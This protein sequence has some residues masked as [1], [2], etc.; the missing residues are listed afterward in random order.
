MS[1]LDQ[2]NSFTG[3]LNL[4]HEQ[5]T[6]SLSN[7]AENLQSQ[8]DDEFNKTIEQMELAGGA[9][10]TAGIGL[11]GIHKSFKGFK[12]WKDARAEKLSKA[13]EDF[14]RSGRAT[15]GG[16]KIDP[17]LRITE[18][19]AKEI[20]GGGK[21]E[22][23]EELKARVAENNRVGAVETNQKF[24]NEPEAQAQGASA[25]GAEAESTSVE[26]LKALRE[27]NPA[28]APAP[29]ALPTTGAEAESDAVSQFFGGIE[30]GGDV[31]ADVA[32]TANVVRQPQGD[33]LGYRRPPDFEAEE[34]ETGFNAFEP[35]DNQPPS[36]RGVPEGDFMETSSFSNA[37]QT[38]G[39]S[40]KLNGYNYES[41]GIFDKPHHKGATDLDEALG[42]AEETADLPTRPNPEFIR[43]TRT[44]LQLRPP[45]NTRMRSGTRSGELLEGDQDNVRVGASRNTNVSEIETSFDRPN[46]KYRQPTLEGEGRLQPTTYTDS[47]I[48]DSATH[49][50]SDPATNSIS[51]PYITQPPDDLN[52]QPFNTQGGKGAEGR[53][54]DTNIQRQVGETG[55]YKGGTTAEADAEPTR[56]L[57]Q[58]GGEPATQP[59]SITQNIGDIPP[60]RQPLDSRGLGTNVGEVSAG[61]E[62]GVG[63]GRT[64]AT[65]AEV[66]AE[67]G[68]EV[69]AEVGSGMLAELG[70]MGTAEIALGSLGPVAEVVGAGF[71][72]AGLVHD[73][74]DKPEEVAKTVAGG[75]SGK[76][77][78]DP[79]SIGG[80][81]SANLGTI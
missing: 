65:G 72:I 45:E 15:R 29:D 48:Q 47:A 23:L 5:M 32:R 62:E 36:V 26:D 16:E 57:P 46:P 20:T 58:S 3:D 25:E 11:S 14:E 69:G 66:G 4:Q 43:E 18:S 71:M 9:V 77:G 30:E 59:Q 21:E 81:G 38:I 34:G 80:G 37:D 42:G 6:A 19:E 67:T 61:G 73:L 50:V 68:A 51:E 35:L 56:G 22:T 64:V 53:G 70:A 13:R 55:D 41:Q 17:D 27:A 63:V 54:A 1:Y 52:R 74:Q 31:S 75:V 44:T 49:I 8:F 79:A 12:K 7:L 28:P 76:I 24:E 40:T 39:G 10:G 78:I 2:L 33:D 60:D